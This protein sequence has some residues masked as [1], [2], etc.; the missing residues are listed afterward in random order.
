VELAEERPFPA[1]E[2]GPWDLAPL[3]REA[4]ALLDRVR[5]WVYLSKMYWIGR[6]GLV[7]TGCKL[8]DLWGN[9]DCE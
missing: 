6:F 2:V 5:I 7:E 8:L 1:D 9:L 3:A 4:M